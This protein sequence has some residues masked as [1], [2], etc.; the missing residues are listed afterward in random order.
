MYLI[1]ILAHVAYFWAS[2]KSV[3]LLGTACD[4]LDQLCMI[5]AQISSSDAC[6]MHAI[7]CRAYHYHLIGDIPAARALSEY[8]LQ[9]KENEIG[10]AH[11]SLLPTLT[12]LG[13]REYMCF[14]LYPCLFLTSSTYS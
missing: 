3:P 1:D 2:V 13:T 4:F 12:L 6:L 7:S 10:N 14:V 5:A 8:A 9:L 11:A